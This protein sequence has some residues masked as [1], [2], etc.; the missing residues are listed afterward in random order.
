MS[1]TMVPVSVT[2]PFPIAPAE[3]PT[4]GRSPVSDTELLDLDAV[5][6]FKSPIS[7]LA[8]DLSVNLSV[9]NSSSKTPRRCLTNLLLSASADSPQDSPCPSPMGSPTRS[10]YRT[11]CKPPRFPDDLK[12]PIRHAGRKLYRS[13]TRDSG[14]SLDDSPLMDHEDISEYQC[15]SARRDNDMLLVY[16]PASDDSMTN[17]DDLLSSDGETEDKACH[18]SKLARPRFPRPSFPRQSTEPTLLQRKRQLMAPA[19]SKLFLDNHPF[20]AEHPMHIDSVQDRDS[21]R[22]GFVPPIKM[23]RTQSCS[24]AQSPSELSIHVQGQRPNNAAIY[25]HEDSLLPWFPGESDSHK[26]IDGQTLVNLLDGHYSSTIEEFYIIDCRFPYEYEGGHIHSA[27]NI[28]TKAELEKLFFTPPITD[29]KVVIV[30]H[31][32]FSSHRAPRM[33]SYMRTQDRQLNLQEY[34]KLHYPEIY[35]LKG[36][37]KNFY[38]EFKPRCFP[39]RY[40]E[41]CDR[42]YLANLKEHKAIHKREFGRSISESYIGQNR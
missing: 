29:K 2:S 12:K 32:E 38:A 11:L 33:A 13:A 41:M 34:P 27:R 5:L 35:V 21:K 26:R 18:W 30:F 22:A 23:R 37:Y 36:G 1:T 42:S 10:D 39:Q 16:S 19:S 7:A 8:T 6:G 20:H 28:N 17:D 4:V 25:G 15:T 24:S 9:L 31:C 40:I 14:V 3:S